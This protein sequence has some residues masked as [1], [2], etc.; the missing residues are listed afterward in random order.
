MKSGARIMR[1]TQQLAQDPPPGISGSPTPENNRYF[2][3]MIEGPAD[4]PF[5]GG[6]FRVEMFLPEEYP[7]VPPKVRFLTKI[8]HP[9][10][11]R[12]GR[13]CLDILKTSWT[14]ALN[15]RT[16]LLSIQSL[17]CEPNLDDPLDN[18]I[19]DHYRR[20]KR[21]AEGTAREWTRLY[22]GG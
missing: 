8:Y 5:Q 11:D 18:Q 15:M 22:A 6:I 10:F 20:N 9:N 12:L 1:E 16:T 2:N 19:A 14:P 13:I 4:T 7:L 21:D 17:L 3:V